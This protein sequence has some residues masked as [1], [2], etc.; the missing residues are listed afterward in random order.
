[1]KL[2]EILL[3]ATQR[4]GEVEFQLQLLQDYPEKFDVTLYNDLIE[5]LRNLFDFSIHHMA[6]MVDQY[7][8]LELC[9]KENNQRME[10]IYN[11]IGEFDLD[12]EG[13]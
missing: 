1:M 12:C 4:A 10:N 8:D 9:T 5:E 11:T 6:I 7:E 13:K 2:Q 3:K